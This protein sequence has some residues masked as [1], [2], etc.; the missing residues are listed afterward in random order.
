[1][2]RTEGQWTSWVDPETGVWQKKKHHP[3]SLTEH[4]IAF[5][6]KNKELLH[7]FIDQM[8]RR[9]GLVPKQEFDGDV[10]NPSKMNQ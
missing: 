2:A 4:T 9:A 5:F 6:K 1:M 10:I 3:I 7:D 8:E